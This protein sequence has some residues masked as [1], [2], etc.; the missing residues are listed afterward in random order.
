MN[1]KR[2]LPPVAASHAKRTGR[3]TLIATLAGLAALSGLLPVQARAQDA[4]H[5]LG[6]SAFVS[7]QPLQELLKK[8]RP[9]GLIYLAVP[10]AIIV[11]NEGDNK[12]PSCSPQIQLTNSSNQTLE[13]LVVG[14][15]YKKAGKTIGSTL[16]RFYLVKTG[17]QDVH[18]F[19]SVLDISACEEAS[20]EAEVIQCLYDTG[21]S[22]AQDVRAL[23]YGAVPLKIQDKK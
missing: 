8:R 7:D 11:A 23:E 19:P 5:H 21:E 15:R 16:S 20:G 1:N 3:S 22:C 6:A 18:Y 9:K 12:K 4:S 10:Q 2:I 14:I 13:E 17:K